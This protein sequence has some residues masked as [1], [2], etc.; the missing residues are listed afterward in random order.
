MD[1]SVSSFRAFEEY[2]CHIDVGIKHQKDYMLQ[3]YDVTFCILLIH[4]AKDFGSHHLVLEYL[5]VCH[6]LI[7]SSNCIDVLE[8]AFEVSSV[9]SI[10]RTLKYLVKNHQI[11]V[12]SLYFV[13]KQKTLQNCTSGIL[14]A[15]ERRK[16]NGN[17]GQTPNLFKKT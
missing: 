15:L 3:N 1:L 14:I 8:L 5:Q 16:R 7:D 13:S 2:L 10:L 17:L 6:V 4:L 12:Q 9:P 11:F